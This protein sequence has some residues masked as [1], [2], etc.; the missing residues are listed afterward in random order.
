MR[1]SILVILTVEVGI[2]LLVIEIV[3]IVKIIVIPFEILAIDHIEAVD[4]NVI[5]VLE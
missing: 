5:I 3:G 4:I 2:V 1:R